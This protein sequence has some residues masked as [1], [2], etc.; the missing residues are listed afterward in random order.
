MS[1]AR[2]MLMR[3][4]RTSP[5]LWGFTVLTVIPAVLFWSILAIFLLVS[6]GLGKTGVT[7]LRWTQWFL[8][9][10]GLTQLSPL[11]GVVVAGWFVVVGLRRAHPPE[12]RRE[13]NLAQAF[14]AALTMAAAVYLFLAIKRGLLGAPD[15]QISGN[16]SGAHLL[17]WYLDRADASLPRPW[18]L[19]VPLFVYRAL[20]LCWALW[21]ADALTRWV[22]WAWEC[23]GTGGLWRGKTAP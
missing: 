2:R 1:C 15:M 21:L 6:V 17:R 7:P 22:R 8:L 9:S 19:S 20:M 16:G 14:L 23:C 12:G 3:N 5:Y 13:F 18:V 4:N 11:G 10:L